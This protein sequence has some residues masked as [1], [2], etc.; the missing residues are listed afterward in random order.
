VGAVEGRSATGW[1]RV[2]GNAN[3]IRS[4]DS[5]NKHVGLSHVQ[6]IGVGVPNG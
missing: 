2:L 5:C 4:S 3:G 1:A 6:S